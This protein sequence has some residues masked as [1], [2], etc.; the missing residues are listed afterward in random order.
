MALAGDLTMAENIF[1][2]AL[3]RLIDWRALRARAARLIAEL[4]FDIPPKARANMLS[5]AHQQVV[6]IA[7]ALS[8]NARVM[9]FDE[10][11]AVLSEQD[12]AWLLD[13]RGLRARGGGR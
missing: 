4:G 8:K 10:P 2:G 1:L 7:K 5:V 6:E 12:A 11:T 13:N 3:P 9:V